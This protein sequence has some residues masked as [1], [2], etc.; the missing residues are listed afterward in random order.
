MLDDKTSRPD[1]LVCNGI[2]KRFGGVV[3]LDRVGLA[4]EDGEIA[5]LIGPNGSG[6]TTLFGILAG[7]H[8]PDAGRV[9]FDGRDMTGLR[10]TEVAGSGLIRTFQQP[11]IYAGLTSLEN[12]QISAPGAGT[13]MR[14]LLARPQAN[15]SR[16]EELLGF[17]GL[18]HQRDRL[19]VQLSFG[20]RK[21]LEF[22]MALMRR[23][24]MLM[25]DEPAA[26]VS[27]D[28]AERMAAVVQEANRTFGLTLLIVE[29]DIPFLLAIASRV[30]CLSRGR[31]VASGTP[32][33]IRTNAA[34]T[35]AYVGTQT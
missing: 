20:Q 15:L 12:M 16:M 17:V 9:T 6:K 18:S 10:E 35:E 27:S 34:V 22:A 23:P 25:L 19:A 14:R 21:L 2:T 5:G 3:A 4:V 26:G 1:V 24:K 30:H 31:L 32:E 13:G 11:Q 33:E 8:Q 28:L 7:H 29:H